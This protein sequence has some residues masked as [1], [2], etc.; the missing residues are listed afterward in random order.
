MPKLCIAEALSYEL[1]IRVI[2]M[3]QQNKFTLVT[4][5]AHRRGLLP[6]MPMA[7]LYGDFIP[8]V[9]LIARLQLDRL[10]VLPQRQLRVRRPSPL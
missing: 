3:W 10:G 4:E 1:M 6:P 8:S 9:A 2:R 7:A 5:T